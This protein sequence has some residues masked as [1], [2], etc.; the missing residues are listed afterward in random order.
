[1]R[2]DGWRSGGHV[3]SN[4]VR[5][6]ESGV[7]ASSHGERAGSQQSRT[8]RAACRCCIDEGSAE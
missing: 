2:L 8:G 1:L 6:A 7:C 4:R 5:G 3:A